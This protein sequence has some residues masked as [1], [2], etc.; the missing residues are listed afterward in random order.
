MVDPRQPRKQFLEGV[1]ER[2]LVDA[3]TATPIA[4]KAAEGGQLVRIGRHL[5]DEGGQSDIAKAV[6]HRV[7]RFAR[8]IRHEL[9]FGEKPDPPFRA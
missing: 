4:E 3:L 6:E 1:F 2:S 5:V 8:L 7:R 9:R